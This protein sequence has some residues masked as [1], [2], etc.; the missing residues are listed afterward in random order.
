MNK[1][2]VIPFVSEVHERSY[3]ENILGVFRRYFEKHGIMFYDDIV[4]SDDKADIAAQKFRDYIVI[5]LIL[6][7][8]TSSLVHKF[9]S[10]ASLNKIILLA[11]S[12]HNSLASAVSARSKIRGEGSSAL[13][14]WCIDPRSLE[15]EIISDYIIRIAKALDYI[16]SLKIVFIV[17]RDDKNVVERNFE[18]R[19]GLSIDL[20]SINDFINYINQISDEKIRETSKLIEERYDFRVSKDH[21]GR[22]ARIYVGMKDLVN[23]YG[24]NVI[25]IDCF[26]FIMRYKASPCIPLSMLNNE[27]VTAVCEADPVAM[28]GMILAKA[29]SSSSGWI[30]NIVWARSREVMF[31]HCTAALDILDEKPIATTHFETSL[32]YGVSGSLRKNVVTIISTDREFSKIY[33]ARGRV[34]RSGLLTET[35]CRTQTIIELDVSTDKFVEYAPS[36]HHVIIFGDHLKEISDIASIYNVSTISYED[37]MR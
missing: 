25:S 28:L 12:E 20:Y 19:F 23:K 5:G 2:V 13:L 37:L 24:Y 9:M 10:K 8:G 32:P 4:S 17:D 35:S 15:C 6:T 26:P 27:G 18:K 33:L 36:N 30:G 3:Y 29:L 31:A 16:S 11:H 21:I 34:I 14:Y 1:I 22:I 7:G